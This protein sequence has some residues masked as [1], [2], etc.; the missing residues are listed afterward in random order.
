M[1][2]GDAG[3]ERGGAGRR[4]SGAMARSHVRMG[5]DGAGRRE[6]DAMARGDARMERWM[7]QQRLVH[8][9]SGAG[10]CRLR[11]NGA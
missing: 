3:V 1:A 8:P 10:L 2:R 9:P 4:E 5:R 7:Q 6:W 11:R